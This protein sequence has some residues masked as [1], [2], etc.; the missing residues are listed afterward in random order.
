MAQQTTLIPLAARTSTL[1]VD[2]DLDLG[3]YVVKCDE[4]MCDEVITGKLQAAYVFGTTAM[5]APRIETESLDMM[6]GTIEDVESIRTPYDAAVPWQPGDEASTRQI[7]RGPFDSQYHPDLRKIIHTLV[8]Y[9]G[10]PAESRCRIQC[11]AIVIGDAA[12]KPVVFRKDGVDIPG[13]GFTATNSLQT[14]YVDVDI[15]HGSS[16]EVW[17]QGDSDSKCR[18]TNM[19]MMAV[20]AVPTMIPV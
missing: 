2:S 7:L 11:Q 10:M 3:A 4:V 12:S 5:V 14:F 6:S 19:R 17:S 8:N 16:L 9:P 13:G 18:I 1:I 20:T 15:Q